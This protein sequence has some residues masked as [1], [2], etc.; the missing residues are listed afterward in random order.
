MPERSP[1]VLARTCFCSPLG[2]SWPEVVGRLERGE[3]GIVSLAERLHDSASPFLHTGALVQPSPPASAR[4]H[5][6]TS[7][8]YEDA[9]AS[10]ATALQRLQSSPQEI[11]AICKRP[12]YSKFAA[13]ETS[14]EAEAEFL[15][16]LLGPLAGVAPLLQLQAACSSGIVALNLAIRNL[17]RRPGTQAL[18]LGV[19]CELQ[20][21]RFLAYKKLGALS[22][23][24][25][26]RR[27]CQPFGLERSGLVPGEVLV[28][29]V[30]ESREPVPGEIVLRPGYAFADAYR[31]TDGLE[32]G[33]FLLACLRRTLGDWEP[34]SLDFVCPH[35]TATPLNDRVEAAALEKLFAGRDR[36]VPLVPL[37]Q[38]TGHCLNSS[39]LWETALCAELLRNNLLPRHLNPGPAERL[40]A[41]RLVDSPERSPLRRALKVSIGFGG[42]NAA[43]LLEKAS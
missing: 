16:A 26:P 5:P 28:A 22:P 3:S 38:Y 43:L 32:S 19:E 7:R 33:E 1:V 11:Y 6:R 42:L 40:Q 15:P 25:D 13:P 35:G 30:L 18:L 10:F 34:D 29:M 9:L 36:P 2:H 21:E 4:L 24:P 8:R 27:A 12:F 41:L 23:E 39:G 14:Y 17:S 37:K 31:L 20:H